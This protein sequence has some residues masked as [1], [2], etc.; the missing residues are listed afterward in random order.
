MRKCFVYNLIKQSVYVVRSYSLFNGRRGCRSYRISTLHLVACTL[1]LIYKNNVL[2]FK[3]N[4]SFVYLANCLY[5]VYFKE[6]R[7]LFF[8]GGGGLV[9]CLFLFFV[10]ECLKLSK[11][12][13]TKMCLYYYTNVQNMMHVGSK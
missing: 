7:M 4:S 5:F 2:D 10:T 11:S 3:N 1:P 12:K 9:V 6:L 8:F 13:L